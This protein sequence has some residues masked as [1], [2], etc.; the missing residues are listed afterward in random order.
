MFLSLV[1]F[2]LLEVT[3]EVTMHNS[4]LTT[5]YVKQTTHILMSMHTHRHRLSHTYTHA[6]TDTHTQ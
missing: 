4:T 6:H 1:D 5:T 2:W 3:F